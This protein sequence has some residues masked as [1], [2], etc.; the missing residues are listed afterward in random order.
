[1]S[2]QQIGAVNASMKQ[3]DRFLIKCKINRMCLQVGLTLR[4]AF[5]IAI[6]NTVAELCSEV[7]ISCKYKKLLAL[8]NTIVLCHRLR[9]P[10]CLI[11]LECLEG[12][13]TEV[14]SYINPRNKRVEGEQS[15]LLNSSANMFTSLE[16]EIMFDQTEI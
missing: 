16:E 14:T 10:F 11:D 6:F 9:V 13:R 3:L 8:C 4:Q 1:M 12:L 5:L 7:T 2:S 15:T